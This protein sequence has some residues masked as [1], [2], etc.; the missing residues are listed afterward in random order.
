[1]VGKE[2]RWLSENH[3][4]D[5]LTKKLKEIKY[6][7]WPRIIFNSSSSP[8]RIMLGHFQ[9]LNVFN[10]VNFVLRKSNLSLVYKI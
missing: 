5:W 7:L 1:M 10:Q 6:H 2:I 8:S 3:N 4:L 9:A